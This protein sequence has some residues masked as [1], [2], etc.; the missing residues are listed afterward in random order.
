MT[1]KGSAVKWEGAALAFVIE[2]VES[3]GPF[4]PAN[5][6]SRSVVEVAASV[7]SQ[8]WFLHALTGHEAYFTLSF[9][10]GRNTFKTVTLAAE[11]GYN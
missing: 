7:K 2:E 10:V 5:W 3:R 4:A 11:S 6:N 1:T 8:G 9:R